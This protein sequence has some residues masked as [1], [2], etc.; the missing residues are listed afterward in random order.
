MHK[1][2]KKLFSKT[3]KS[4]MQL[5]IRTPYATLLKDFSQ[6]HRLITRT[7]EGHFVIQNKTPPSTH[8]L[9]PG[10]LKVRLEEDV[11]NFSGDILHLGG[12]LTVHPDNTCEIALMDY[13]EKKEFKLDEVGEISRDE[14]SDGL[15]SV[16]INR[17]RNATYK[18][19]F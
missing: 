8:V 17:I 14:E 6:F 11:A 18:S 12:W 9:P 13:V 7:S 2:L 10:F 16:Y 19:F 15:A 3:K 5:S 4:K 1:V